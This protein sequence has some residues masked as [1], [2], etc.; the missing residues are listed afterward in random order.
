MTA[1]IKVGKNTYVKHRDLWFNTKAPAAVCD[2]LERAYFTKLRVRIWMGDQVTGRAWAA[3]HDVLGRIGRSCGELKVPLLVERG[4]DGGAAVLDTSIVRIDVAPPWV[5][6]DNT[7]SLYKHPSF[8]TGSW[9]TRPA[10]ADGYAI[11]VLHDGAVYARCRKAEQGKRL[12]RFMSGES[13][14]RP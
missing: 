1:S 12:A 2:A 14:A 5:R 11:E 9:E 6:P 3:E 13:Y 7:Y 4:K 10:E 8:H